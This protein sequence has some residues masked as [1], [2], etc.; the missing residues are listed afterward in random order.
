MK[1]YREKI[2]SVEK[3]LSFVES[4][5]CIMTAVAAAAPQAFLSE[6]KYD[7][8]LKLIKRNKLFQI[9]PIVKQ[10][11]ETIMPVWHTFKFRFKI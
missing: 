6:L 3:A 2:I 9:S 4:D 10:R 8:I 1:E 7:V 11:K 5:S